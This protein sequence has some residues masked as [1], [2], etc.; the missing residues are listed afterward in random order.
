LPV[1]PMSVFQFGT[2]ESFTMVLAIP[3]LVPVFM[4]IGVSL[5]IGISKLPRRPSHKRGSCRQYL[6]VK[7][8][9]FFHPFSTCAQQIAVISH[10]REKTNVSG[11][12]I[13]PNSTCSIPKKLFSTSQDHYCS[14]SLFFLFLSFYILSQSNKL[15][16]AAISECMKRSILGGQKEMKAR[17][18]R[19]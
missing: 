12:L 1:F 4:Q 19:E 11:A 9:L 6:S 5:H 18:I 7:W 2:K 8:R 16:V 3:K 10:R 14:C 15:H 13:P 17:V